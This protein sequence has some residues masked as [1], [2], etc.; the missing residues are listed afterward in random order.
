MTTGNNFVDYNT[1][2]IGLRPDDNTRSIREL[3]ETE[4]KKGYSD[5]SDEE[6]SNLIEYKIYE[7]KQDKEMELLEKETN[8]RIQTGLDLAKQ[9][10]E[11]TMKM[12][13]LKREPV[14]KVI[15][16]DGSKVNG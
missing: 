12:I 16:D 9:M 13:G 5:M 8:A 11:D 6:I 10:R 1:R 7:A 3:L 15:E 14:F 4:R 2:Y